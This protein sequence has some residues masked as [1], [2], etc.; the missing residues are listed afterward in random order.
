MT[1]VVSNDNSL[2]ALIER[3]EREQPE[4]RERMK[5]EQNRLNS[6]TSRSFDVSVAQRLTKAGFYCCGFGFTQCFSCRLPK[7]PTRP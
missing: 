5:S 3:L 1:E 6:F 4:E 7:H 2:E